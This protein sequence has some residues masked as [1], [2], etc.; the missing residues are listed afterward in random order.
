MAVNEKNI[1]TASQ[2]QSRSRYELL[3]R[4]AA[5]PVVQRLHEKFNATIVDVVDL[6]AG[7]RLRNPGM[8]PAEFWQTKIFGRPAKAAGVMHDKFSGR[9]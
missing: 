6:R 2:E 5:G 7:E 9:K 3:E 1:V 4:V 8:L